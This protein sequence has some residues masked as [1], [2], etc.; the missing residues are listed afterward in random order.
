MLRP[1]PNN[2][3]LTR[4][5]GRAHPA[6]M[7]PGPDITRIAAQIGEPARANIL[8]ALM[9]G[10][11]LT[12]GELALEA[13]VQPATA[14]GHLRQM[15]DAGLISPHKQGRHRYFA[16]SGPDVAHVLEA[17]IGLAEQQGHKRTRPG[18]RDPALRHARIC[19]DHLAGTVAVRVFDSLTRQGFLK[20][21]GEAL[22]LSPAGQT[23][24]TDM[25]LDL[26]VLKAKRR[27]LCRV[28][29]DWSERRS[30]LAGSLGAALYAH[31]LGNGWARR[32]KDSRL[33][34]ITPKGLTEL[35]E[36]FGL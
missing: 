3:G 9:G 23:F 2:C 20:P 25:G 21:G 16:L 27:P 26:P 28:C 6:V 5:P 13:G 12:A 8:Q 4:K 24:F 17:L 31:M 14:S 1:G 29:L 15:Q 35:Q 10:Q 36:R 32:S 7:K 33:V 30:H 19:Y 18:P 22:T 11:A 34:T